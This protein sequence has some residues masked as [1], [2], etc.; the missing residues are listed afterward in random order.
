MMLEHIIKNLRSDRM[1]A[2]TLV[3]NALTMYRGRVGVDL[4]KLIKSLIKSLI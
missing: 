3:L 1:T 4:I 2:N